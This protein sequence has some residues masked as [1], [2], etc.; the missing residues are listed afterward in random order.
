VVVYTRD[1][2][3]FATS[4]ETANDVAEFPYYFGPDTSSLRG[5]ESREADDLPPSLPDDMAAA[6]VHALTAFQSPYDKMDVAILAIGIPGQDRWLLMET[7]TTPGLFAERYEAF[8][9]IAASLTFTP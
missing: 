3:D 8:L 5:L 1:G 9:E 7:A 4:Q 6:R 2:G